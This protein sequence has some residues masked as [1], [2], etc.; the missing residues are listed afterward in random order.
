MPADKIHVNLLTPNLESESVNSLFTCLEAE[1]L[2]AP[3]HASRDERK[4]VPYAHQSAVELAAQ[5]PLVLWRVSKPCFDGMLMTKRRANDSLELNINPA[6]AGTELAALFGAFS[7]VAAR[8]PLEFGLLH[9][10]FVGRPE[11]PLYNRGTHVSGQDLDKA[12]LSNVHA[13]TWFGPYLSLPS[14][15]SGRVTRGSRA[16]SA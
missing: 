16:D 15:V 6:P 7:H 1:P 3:A 10:Y 8:M 4:R 13:R 14:W 11:G 9:L 2:L 12:G 5:G